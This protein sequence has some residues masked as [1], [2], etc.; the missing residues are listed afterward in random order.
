MAPPA[1]S[2][3]RHIYLAITVAA[4]GYFVDV[5]DLILVNVVRGPSVADLGVPKAEQLDKAEL[6]VNMQM[7]GMLAG[8]LV[9]GA[10]GD[11]KGR[12]SV[13]FGSIALYSV[14]NLVNAQVTDLTQY[15]A[16][17]FITGFGLAGE[18]GAGVTLV[19]EIMSKEGRGWG[20]TVIAGIG[21][22]GGVGATLLGGALP[23][24]WHGVSWRAA[25]VVGGCMGMLL[26]VLRIGVHE[27]GMF[28]DVAKKTENRGNF[29]AIFKTW[30]RA[31]RYLG[32]VAVGLPVWYVI[33]ILAAAS[34]EIGADAGMTAA[35][36]PTALMYCYI[37]LGV[38]DVLAGITS[39][40]MRSR[41]MA[42]GIFLAATALATVAYFTIGRSSR[43]AYFVAISA[44]SIA[45]GYWAIFVI[46][47]SEQFGTNLRA[48]ATTT[49]PNFVRGGLFAMNEAFK[50][51]RGSLGVVGGA[52]TVGAVV[53]ALAFVGLYAVD[54]TFGRDLDFVE[55]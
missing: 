13:L 25:Y 26:L 10:L 46:T 19:N 15:A 50:G 51:L 20:P 23:S 52:A 45:G 27:S 54:E 38:G 18:L 33:G 36:R 49:A 44:S 42:L 32:I 37:F 29:L 5:F 14:G 34:P 30:P 7:L 3:T 47:A 55:E 16:I 4:L 41:K 48:T 31:R 1:R 40:W 24:V 9:W 2:P 12:L 21:I 43:E 22:L 6:I 39:Q 28:K 35:D 11:K 17:R 53:I 8:G